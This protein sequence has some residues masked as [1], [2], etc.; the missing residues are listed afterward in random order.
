MHVTPQSF[1][2]MSEKTVEKKRGKARKA[3]TGSWTNVPFSVG[4]FTKLV[5]ANNR[6]CLK[7]VLVSTQAVPSLLTCIRAFR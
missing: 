5:R 4:Y 2:K 6:F 7:P 1:D 3:G